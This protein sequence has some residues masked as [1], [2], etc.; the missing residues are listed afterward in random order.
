[1]AD[2]KDRLGY[3]VREGLNIPDEAFNKHD[4]ATI[5]VT[6][7]SYGGEWM[8]NAI[9][10][11][12]SPD[13]ATAIGKIRTGKAPE[14]P[15]LAIVAAASWLEEECTRQGL[16]LRVFKDK[17]S[18]YSP[19][20]APYFAGCLALIDRRIDLYHHTEPDKA[21]NIL[22]DRRMVDLSGRQ[23]TV[24]F[25]TVPHGSYGKEYGP[26]VVHVRVPMG[27]ATLADSFAG[28]TEKFYTVLASDLRPEHFI[29]D[30]E[31]RSGT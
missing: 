17:N 8:L 3:E 21:A 25:S 18:D 14:R 15:D 23:D 1:M 4:I 19:D 11:H 5:V 26:S 2:Q 7:G 29:D 16:S 9:S 30:E 22:K 31:M 28:G 20:A 12:T 10:M 13:E 6:G 24:H 27:I